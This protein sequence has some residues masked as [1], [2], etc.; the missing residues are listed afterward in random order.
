[1]STSTLIPSLDGKRLAHQLA[2]VRAVMVMAGEAWLTL[3]EIETLT[4][5][6]Q[7]SISARLR[8]LRGLGYDVQRRRRGEPSRGLFEYRAVKRE[9]KQEV[10][11]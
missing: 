9:P 2:D 7:A 10:L 3:G 5:Y 4:R 1:V 8:E 6:P 11:F